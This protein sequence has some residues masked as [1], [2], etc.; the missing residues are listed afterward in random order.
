MTRLLMLAFVASTITIP[1]A[2]QAVCQ[3][4]REEATHV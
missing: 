1:A 2:G 4:M 3:R